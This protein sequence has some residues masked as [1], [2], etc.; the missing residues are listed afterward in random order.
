MVGVHLAT[1]K[2]EYEMDWNGSS[3]H[4]TNYGC[5]YHARFSILGRTEAWTSILANLAI[6]KETDTRLLKFKAFV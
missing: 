3:V 2:F 6:I 4:W 5:T 1:W